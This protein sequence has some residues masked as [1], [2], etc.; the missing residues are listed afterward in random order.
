MTSNDPGD[1]SSMIRTD[2]V[3]QKIELDASGGSL[4]ANRSVD[5]SAN[6]IVGELRSPEVTTRYGASR[7]HDNILQY[8]CFQN[9]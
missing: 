2:R 1:L 7:R 4:S 6:I 3:T 9:V 5:K 8:H